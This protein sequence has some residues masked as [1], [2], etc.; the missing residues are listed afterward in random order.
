VCK[1]VVVGSG[2][3]RE[4]CAGV[5]WLDTRAC[6]QGGLLLFYMWDSYSQ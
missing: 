4:G 6:V 5:V 3:V 2:G 1:G